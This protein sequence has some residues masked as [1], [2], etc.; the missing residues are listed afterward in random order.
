[1]AEP[2][3]QQAHNGPVVDTLD[4]FNVIACSTCGFRHILPIPTTQELIHI[5]RDDYYKTE[6]PLYIEDVSRDLDWWRLTYSDRYEEFARQLPEGRRR[7]LD[8]GSG[9][10][11]F[12]QYGQQHGWQVRG[13]EPSRQAAAHARSL[14]LDIVEGLLDHNSAPSLGHYDVVHMN[15]VLEHI[16]DPLTL[17]DLCYNLLDQDGLICAVVPNDYNPFQQALRDTCGFAP[18][19]IAPPHHIN[20]FDFDSLQQALER[21]GF[22]VFLRETTFPI[23]MF[24]LMG[25]N[26]VNDNTLG[27]ACHVK[28]MNFERNLDRSGL[29]DVKRRLYQAMAQQGLGRE[30]VLMGRKPPADENCR[31]K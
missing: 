28:R 5:Y 12:L 31:C 24:L 13:I 20:Y 16:P 22:E 26:Y 19:W 21:C 25:D 8:I 3:Q 23:D 4:G 11:F 18:W 15:N 14:G 10:G 27:R 29:N 30:I 7:L 17:L 9:P 6:K 1:M 2:Q